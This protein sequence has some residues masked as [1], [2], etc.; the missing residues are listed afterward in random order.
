[1][2]EKELIN[3][4]GSVEHIVFANKENG[5]AVIEVATGDEL[6]CA[7][8]NIPDVQEGTELS[9]MGYYTTHATYGY[10][11]RVE[12][13]EQKMPATENAICKYLA[14]GT[15][16]GIGPA[17]A[18]RIVERF[19][20]DTLQIMEEQP[21]RLAEVK[22][23]TLKKSREL[24]EEV[25]QVFGVRNLMIFLSAYGVPP[26]VSVKVWKKWGVLSA[27]LLRENPYLLCGSLFQLDFSLADRIAEDQNIPRDSELRISA[28][29]GC[30]L[31]HNIGN[32]HTCLPCSKL[33][34]AAEKLLELPA[35][36]IEEKLE[37]IVR[38]G[39]LV[40]LRKKK[41]YLALPELFAAEQY[42]AS[43]ISL[44]VSVPPM[45]APQIDFVIRQVEEEKKLRYEDLQKKA[46]REALMN[47]IFILTGGPGTGKTTTLNGIIDVLEYCGKDIAI[48]APTGRAAKRIS[49]VTGRE[50]KTIHRLL[51]VEM[52]DGNPRFAKNEQEPLLNDAVV[53]DEMSMVD[54]LLFDALLRAMKPGAK[55][56]LVG[57]YNQLPSVGAG[58]VLHDL[59]A[60]EVVPTVRLEQ[61]F[62]QAAQSNIVL[63][64][65]RIVEGT[66]PDLSRKD[67]DFFFLP[68]QNAPA[69]SQTVIDLVCR[70]L[71]NR[72]QYSP[73]DDIQVLCPQRRGEL[74]VEELNS[75]LQEQLNPPA[76]GKTEFK[77]GLYTYRVGDKVMQIKNN[78]DM[79][80]Q[81][82]TERGM[83]VFNGDIGTI[84]MI[85]RG[86]Q[87]LAVEF[88]DRLSYYPFDMAADQLELAYA[89]T[90]HK[91]QGNEFEA[92]V[93]PM[94]GGYD[95]L[96]YRNLL[97]TAITRAKQ[98]VI[99]VGRKERVA[100]MVNNNLKGIRFTNLKH[101]LVGMVEEF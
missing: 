70:R 4:C 66:V 12:T 22:G 79:E 91:S 43:R 50:A 101:L 97:Y 31:V 42:I 15:I 28:G 52:G 73:L 46:I 30:I 67:G 39:D 51:E 41:E 58:N 20:K 61:I 74:G 27:E 99:L 49:E 59:L 45:E 85:D 34:Q 47:E 77:A 98:I 6:V 10:Q 40:R 96:Y 93:I 76:P 23:I 69:V 92:V 64:A 62:R 5:F 100:F 63:N 3:L 13:C 65:H 29:L 57:D 82:D 1:M 11:F 33:Y 89:I 14:S 75:R 38:Q 19:G 60:S 81:K 72:Y 9:M 68:R 84:R 36:T 88:E 16:K 87:T 21:E 48:A 78:Y 90:V 83:G 37:T 53:I 7:V 80:W 25:R 8:G 71:P 56:I 17:I 86:S 94:L 24:A 95:R 26:A 55:L 54:V 35:Q 2:A 18:R 44:M 32:G